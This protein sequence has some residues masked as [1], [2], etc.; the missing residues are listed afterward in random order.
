MM[1][2]TALPGLTAA[3]P[4]IETDRLVLRA[5]ALADLPALTAFFATPDSHFVGGPM[6]AGDTHRAML[7]TIGSWALYGYGL[8]HI[9]DKATDRFVGWTGLLLTPGKSEPGFAWTVLPAFQGTGL[10]TE[11][12]RAALDHV[13]DRLGHPAPATYIDSENTASAAVAR[14]LGFVAET[15]NGSELTYRYHRRAA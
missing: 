12:A 1:V 13:G 2:A 9:A 8:W 11:A 4:V 14:K 10:A 15:R 7:A 5:P 6:G 3:I